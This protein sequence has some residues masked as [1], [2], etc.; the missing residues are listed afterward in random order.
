M[1]LDN[2]AITER[3][4]E[5]LHKAAG[6]EQEDSPNRRARV[7]LGGVTAEL[8]AAGTDGERWYYRVA[9]TQHA[10]ELVGHLPTD[11]DV[12]LQSDDPLLQP[13]IGR[14]LLKRD[15]WQTYLEQWL[16]SQ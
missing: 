9:T 3:L 6:R 7:T 8:W 2:E 5:K 16:R 4:L 14:R 15:D 11:V 10:P 12:G 13:F 1:N